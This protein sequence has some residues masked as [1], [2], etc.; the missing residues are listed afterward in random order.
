MKKIIALIVMGVIGLTLIGCGGGDSGG[1]SSTTTVTS[2]ETGIF[3]DAPVEG[4]SYSTPTM[5]GYTNALG[6]FQYKAGET[7]TFKIGH[8]VL[9][10]AVGSKI[11][12]PLTLTGETDLNNIS[13]K[14]TNIARLLQTLDANTSNQGNIELPAALHDLNVSNINLENESD[15]NVLL[16]AAQQMTL[17]S[18]IL[19]DSIIAKNE[20]KNFVQLYS[21]YE[22]FQNKRYFGGTTQ[23]YVLNMPSN[24]NVD[25]TKYHASTNESNSDSFGTGFVQLYDTNMTLIKRLDSTELISA[26]TYI[27]KISGLS[28]GSYVDVYSRLLNPSLTFSNLTN[29]RYF[30]GSTQYYVLNMPSNGNVD[31]TKYW[32]GNDNIADAFGYGFVR[33]YDSNMTLI[34]KLNSNESITAGTYIV[35]ISGLTSGSY[36]DVYSPLL[37]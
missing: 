13:V 25:L 27:V 31:F 4:L 15:L 21:Q 29:K 16:S 12:T 11:M 36:V 26:G 8:F 23:Y 7:V 30:G 37:N 28:S 19:K 10:S 20:M 1:S 34:R 14:A 33:L 24:G 18:Y 6:E 2:T 32:A 35:K 3:I 9:G 22:I 5:S 17:T